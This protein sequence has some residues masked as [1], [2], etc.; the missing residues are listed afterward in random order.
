MMVSQGIFSEVRILETMSVDEYYSTL[1]AYFDY[2]DEEA[3]ARQN[4]IKENEQQ[5]IIRGKS[6]R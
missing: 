3:R 1:M 2:R 6:R 4:A 5:A